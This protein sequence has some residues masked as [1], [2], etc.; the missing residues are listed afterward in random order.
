MHFD[1]CIYTEDIEFIN[2]N[3]QKNCEK[4]PLENHFFIIIYQDNIF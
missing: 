2:V 4:L 1:V 3:F